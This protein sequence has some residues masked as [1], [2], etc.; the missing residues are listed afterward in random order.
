M[1]RR[2]GG[3]RLDPGNLMRQVQ[4]MQQEVERIQS[5]VEQQVVTASVGGG[6]VEVS[7]TGGLEVRDIAIK[8]DVVD[9]EDVEMLQDLILAAVNEAI[10]K[11]RAMMAERMSAVTGGMGLPGL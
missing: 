1:S 2:G 5:E 8:P 7:I 11:A 3:M 4:Q 9:P 10:Q 6:A